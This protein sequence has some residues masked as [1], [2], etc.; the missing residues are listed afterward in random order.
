MSTRVAIEAELANLSTMSENATVAFAS[1]ITKL[2]E[3]LRLLD[4]YPDD[5]FN[6][7]EVI[8]FTKQFDP[9]GQEYTFAAIKAE[10][11][12]YLTGGHLGRG[13]GVYTW[14]KLCEWLGTV[15][16]PTLSIFW[17]TEW[18]DIMS[19]AS[20]E[21]TETTRAA[22]RCSLC[23]GSGHDKRNCPNKGRESG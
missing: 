7:G 15:G 10:D 18:Q 14:E 6:D 16:V 12:W 4:S 9:A 3:R 17:A 23:S 19:T 13:G 8:V 2:H 11:R 22:K 1:R 21:P 20:E 5:D